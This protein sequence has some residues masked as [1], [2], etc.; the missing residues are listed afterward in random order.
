[1]SPQNH[2]LSGFY[3]Y[4]T[5]EQPDYLGA[6]RIAGGRQ[7]PALMTPGHGVALDVPAARVEGGVQRGPRIGAV[8]RGPRRAPT[9]RCGRAT[10]SPAAPRIEDIGNNFVSGGVWSTDLRRHRPQG[11]A[12]AG[13][14]QERLGRQPQFQARRRGDARP[15][16]PAV[17]RLPGRDASLVGAQQQR[18]DPGRHLSARIR[19]EERPLDLLRV[20]ERLVAARPPA[21]GERRHPLRSPLRLPARPGRSGRPVASPRRRH[22]H[23][24]Q[25]GPAPGRQLRL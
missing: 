8:L 10:A 5:K 2:K 12:V 4:Q 17:P 21:D 19:I 7:S 24:Q 9:T 3:Q 23:L 6:I 14:F 1:M 11:N 16:R 25:L 18:G 20:P 15:A 22:R 13:V